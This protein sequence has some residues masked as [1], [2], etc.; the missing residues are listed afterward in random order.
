MQGEVTFQAKRGQRLN[1]AD[2]GIRL[3]EVLFQ[4][5]LTKKWC[6]VDTGDCV[7]WPTEF[8]LHTNELLP[9][10]RSSS[11]LEA[12]GVI[13]VVK[14]IGGIVCAVPVFSDCDLFGL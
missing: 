13:G 12:G 11:L 10:F 5:L 7:N 1:R 3:G 2:H 8:G 4:P 6:H 14:L 9:Q